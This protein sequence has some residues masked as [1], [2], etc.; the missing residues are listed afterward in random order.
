[1]SGRTLFRDVDERRRLYRYWVRD[2][3]AGARVFVGYTA[4]RLLPTAIVSSI[5]SRLGGLA[6]KLYPRADERARLTLRALRPDL[7]ADAT[8]LDAAMTRYWDSMGRVYTEF[9]V[10]DRLWDEGRVKVEGA[11]HLAE[12]RERGCSAIIAGI[13]LGNWEVLPI[14]LGYL[15]D[16]FVQIYQPLRNRFET[17]L[18]LKSRMRCKARIEAARPGAYCRF[19]PPSPSMPAKLIRALKAGESFMMFVDEHIDGRV[20][21]PAFGRPR[22]I[23]GNLA[24]V[25]RLSRMSGAALIPAYVTRE[26]GARFTVHYL[27]PLSMR[28][29]DDRE[30]DI[31]GNVAALNDLFEDVVRRH[32][33]QWYMLMDLRLER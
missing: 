28:L 2:P 18:A 20:Q 6:P 5:G 17:R 26:R 24:R 12:T 9:S 23:D 15:V 13:H 25:V 19:L 16:R 1:M 30:A 32:V 3:L 11:E 21:A 7:A 33:D 14:S 8:A 10:E 22:T 29:S 27:P 31:A 4:L